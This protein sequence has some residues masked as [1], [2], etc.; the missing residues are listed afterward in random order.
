MFGIFTFDSDEGWVQSHFFRETFLTSEQAQ[1]YLDM[2]ISKLLHNGVF[3]PGNY[4]EY[5]V[6]PIAQRASA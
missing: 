3:Q 6:R 4:P 2:E 5:M 1:T